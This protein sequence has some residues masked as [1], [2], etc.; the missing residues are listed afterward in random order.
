M[1]ASKAKDKAILMVA[2]ARHGSS[3][4]DVPWANASVQAF[5]AR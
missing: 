2:G 1:K 5:L 4:L 3:V